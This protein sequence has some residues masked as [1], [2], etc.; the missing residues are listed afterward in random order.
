MIEDLEECKNT[1]ND[2]RK[3]SIILKNMNG[4]IKVEKD[5]MLESKMTIE[6]LWH[7]NE[8][9]KNYGTTCEN[10]TS[11]V[12]I[13]N[14]KED[15]ERENM[16]KNESDVEACEREMNHKYSELDEHNNDLEDVD[17]KCFM[18]ILDELE[19]FKRKRSTLFKS[20]GEYNDVLWSKETMEYTKPKQWMKWSDEWIRLSK[21][22]AAAEDV[23]A[24]Q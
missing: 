19:E 5:N 24:L 9:E 2:V 10:E 22:L 3:E 23:K 20:L 14:Q 4:M 15:N 11:E 21:V 7:L 12:H 13:E 16:R 8:N 17:K 6:I 1:L 18:M